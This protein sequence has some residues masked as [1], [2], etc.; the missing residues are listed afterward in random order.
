MPE[1]WKVTRAKL[2]SEIFVP[3]RNKPELNESGEGFHWT[4]MEDM[5][6]DVIN[7]TKR[8]VSQVAAEIAGSKILKKG[9]VVASCV[10]NF[11]VASVL[12]IDAVINQQLQAY[13]PNTISGPYLRDVITCSKVYFELV[14]TA[15]TLVY[16]N[17]EGFGNLPVPLPP[18]D[19]QR[20]IECHVKQAKTKFDLA[21]EK[22]QSQVRLLQERRIALISAAVTGKIDVRNWTPDS[23]PPEQ[24]ELMAAEPTAEYRV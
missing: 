17:Q 6:G 4:T 11:G 18:E 1:H 13:I 24:D 5:K 21:M 3:Q 9:A 19:E 15:A 12:N 10:G 2:A 14:G 20:E 16:V 7:T 22:A 23:Q 8:Y